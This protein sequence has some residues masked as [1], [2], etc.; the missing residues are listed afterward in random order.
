[1]QDAILFFFRF[2][3]NRCHC[4]WTYFWTPALWRNKQKVNKIKCPQLSD[5]I[6]WA[7]AT[8][9]SKQEHYILCKWPFA[10]KSLGKVRPLRFQGGK[11]PHMAKGHKLEGTVKKRDRSSF[12][13]TRGLLD[14]VIPGLN[15]SLQ[16]DEDKWWKFIAII[17][18]HRSA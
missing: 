5:Y 14:K 2:L 10:K 9:R 15:C 4:V 12:Q 1:M 17:I 7:I 3:R 6:R 8:K 13:A 18:F 11:V 16:P